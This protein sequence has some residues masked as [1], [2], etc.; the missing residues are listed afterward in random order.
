M[1]DKPKETC[2]RARGH[3]SASSSS[4]KASCCLGKYGIS[5]SAHRSHR[6][7]GSAGGQGRKVVRPHAQMV[8]KGHN[9]PYM[10]LRQVAGEVNPATSR[11]SGAGCLCWKHR[12]GRCTLTWRSS[13]LGAATSAWHA[14]Q[15]IFAG[16]S[17]SRR[18]RA[19][20]SRQGLVPFGF[21][22]PSEA[23]KQIKGWPN[24]RTT[25]LHTP[26]RARD[27][28]VASEAGQTHGGVHR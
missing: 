28:S 23:R 19:P 16:R 8:S 1:L 22:V 3:S 6:M 18:C 12:T 4:F 10:S 27:C 20:S 21:F 25:H 2:A 15:L 9:V 7:G 24:G 14:P 17:C 13:P 26:I 11:R 5:S